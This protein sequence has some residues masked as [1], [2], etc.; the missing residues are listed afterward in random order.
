[1]SDTA[2]LRLFLENHNALTLAYTDASGVG[3]CAVWYALQDLNTLV[4]LSAISTRHGAALRDGGPVAFTIHKDDQDWRAITGVQGT[5]HCAPLTSEAA[6]AAWRAYV[7]RFPFV[8]AQFPALETALA[9]TAV[10]SLRVNWIRLI[11]NSIK[12]GHKTEWHF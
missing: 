6:G 10:F 2:P 12:F 5:G 3:A 7:T 8:S 1:M 4:F 9:R 11:D